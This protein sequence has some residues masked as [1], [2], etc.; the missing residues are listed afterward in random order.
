MKYIAIVLILVLSSCKKQEECSGCNYI[1]DYYQIIYKA[2][3]EY[4]TENY[5]KAFELY[6]KAFNSCAVINTPTYNELSNFA[7]TCAI[8]GEND[9]AIKFIKKR[10]KNGYEI[11]WLMENPNFDKVFASE[12]GRE[13]VSNYDKLRKDA[14]YNL[15]LALREEIK[16]MGVE[17]Q[18]YRNEK[19]TL[20]KENAAKQEAIDDYNTNRIIEIFN[21][22][23]YP[24]ETIIG[25]FSVDRSSVNISTILLHTSDSIRMNYFVP[26]LTEFVR[27][28]SCPPNVL[29]TIIDQ[30]YLY[31]GEPQINGT[32]TKPNGNY[33]SMIPN[34]KKV[35]SN[36][37]SIGLPPLRL[38]EKKDSLVKAKYGY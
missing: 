27:N 38:Q 31:N 3:V 6:Q 19:N 33:S 20:Y 9:L 22:F 1:T 14:L 34:L 28:G 23:G 11:K 17:D 37:I 30:Y 15:N 29:G 32:Y 18:K 36:R 7:E 4:M 8:L 12:K 35:D 21:E 24:N 5:E 2:D 16:A 10:I 25:G 13:L 26:K